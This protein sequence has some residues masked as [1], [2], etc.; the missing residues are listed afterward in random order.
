MYSVIDKGLQSTLANMLTTLAQKVE[1]SHTVLIVVDVQND[2]CASGGA[3]HRDGMDLSMVQDMVPRLVDFID[4]AR[5]V[6]IS[7]VYI[8]SYYFAEGNPYLTDAF[9]EQRSR[10]GK[11]RHLEFRSCERGSWGA[12][13]Y[14]G[15]RPLPGESIVNKQCYSAFI[16]TDLDLILRTRKIRTLLMTGVSSDVC[17]D[18]TTR[19]GFMYGYYTVV[20]K[21]LCATYSQE[22]HDTTLRKIDQFYGQVVTSTDVLE[23]WKV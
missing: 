4:K 9:L 20:L 19:V 13:F 6:G 12:E 21:D 3:F 7:I 1:P 2:F 10:S 11:K 22:L 16:G 17:V 8:Q 23:C 15:I 5:K 18:N 14:Q